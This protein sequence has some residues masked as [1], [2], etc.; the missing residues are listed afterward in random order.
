[1]HFSVGGRWTLRFAAALAIAGVATLG[2]TGSIQRP[3]DE[4]AE[5]PGLPS[6]QGQK[7]PGAPGNGD[8]AA[9]GKGEPGSPG[10][11]TCASPDPGRSPLRRLNREEWNNTIRDLVGDDRRLAS[12]FVLDEQGDGF[13]NNADALIVTDLGAYQYMDAAEAV[14]QAAVT[15]LASLLPCDPQKT[16]EMACAQQFVEVFGRRAFRRPLTPQEVQRF[17]ALWNTGRTGGTFA[18]GIELLVQ[19]FLQSPHFLYRVERGLPAQAR[20][21]AVPLTSYEMAARLSYFVWGS[22]PDDDLFKAAAEDRLATPAGIEAQVRRLLADK[23][24]HEMVATFHREF[25]DLEGMGGLV[26]NSPLWTASLKD[27]LYREATTFV[28]EVFWNDGRTDTMLAAPYSYLNADLARHYGATGPTGDTLVKTPLDPKQ[29]AGIVTMAGLLALHSYGDQSSPIHRGEF[30]RERLL[31]QPLPAPPN[32]VVIEPPKVDPKASTKQRFAQHSG[33][34]ACAGCHKLMDPI[35]LGFEHYDF[36]GRWRDRD[37][38]FPVDDEGEVFASV[39]LD[40]KFKGGVELAQKLAASASVRQCF[41]AQWFRYANGRAETNADACTMSRL[42]KR[43]DENGHDLRDL[44]IA[45]ATSDA[46]R[47]RALHGGGQ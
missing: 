32:D 28:E 5:G 29:R 25:L 44:L 43:L 14:A 4:G 42:G 37:G 13:T 11:A 2:C 47:Y 19:M 30:V 40:G 41:A 10:A 7:P 15:R 22:M 17:V 3:E 6:Q 36:M 35:G 16:G 21:N 33:D 46:F 1:M 24:S 18:D 20:G 27:A 8:P 12:K 31:C 38:N 9:P 23:R 45:I 34:P 39:D 26:K